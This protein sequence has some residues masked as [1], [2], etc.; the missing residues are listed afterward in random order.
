MPNNWIHNQ[1]MVIQ[2]NETLI[3]KRS[4]RLNSLSGYE[5]NLKFNKKQK[6][7]KNILQWAY[8]IFIEIYKS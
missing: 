2:S 3:K 5:G 8:S 4:K 6:L 1:V 7:Y